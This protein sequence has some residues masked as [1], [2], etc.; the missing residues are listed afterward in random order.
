MEEMSATVI[1]VAKNAQQVS[2]S[3]TEAQK[4]A[5]G[6][7]EIVRDTIA[8]MQEVSESTTVTAGM[9][10]KL[11]ESSEEIGSIIS[12][13]ND[14]ADQTN[15]LALNAAIE[16]ARAG[17]QGRGFAVVADEVRKL[18]ERTTIATK[19]ISTMIGS[20]QTETST[21][22]TA[23]SEGTEKVENGVKLANATEEALS[24]IVIGVQSVN[25]MVRQIATST[26]EQSATT[27]EISRNMDTITEVAS[28]SAASITEVTSTITG[29]ARLATELKGLVSGFTVDETRGEAQGSATT[30]V[31]RSDRRDADSKGS[32]WR[33]GASSLRKTG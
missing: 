18:A 6:G 30:T 33:S 8:A 20:I 27:D 1:E 23:M 22:V 26:E 29:V 12:V 7:G 21:A 13:I 9:I 3:S 4:T 14:I 24:Q 28:S 17:E 16:A 32:K 31:T 15:L 11:G 10:E 25:D 5:A 2:E 19:E